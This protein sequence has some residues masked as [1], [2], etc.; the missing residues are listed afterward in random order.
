MSAKRGPS[1]TVSS[2]RLG[3]RQLK[4]I[5]FLKQY[6]ASNLASGILKRFQ[7]KWSGFG[8]ECQ[9]SGIPKEKGRKARWSL[10][11]VKKK[12]IIIIFN[13]LPLPFK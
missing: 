7:R 5:D 9:K 3:T 6:L 12:K 1:A 2:E 13:S 8:G 4:G 10:T 11:H